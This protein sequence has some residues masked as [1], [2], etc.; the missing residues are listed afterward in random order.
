MLS[1]L[2][3]HYGDIFPYSSNFCW[4][5]ISD[6]GSGQRFFPENRNGTIALNTGFPSATAIK[7]C[8]ESIVSSQNMKMHRGT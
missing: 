8:I 1:P 5:S 2:N 6:S 7:Y 3:P 4:M